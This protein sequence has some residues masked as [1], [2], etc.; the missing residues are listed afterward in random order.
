M[1]STRHNV[2][3]IVRRSEKI[4]KITVRF[5]VRRTIFGVQPFH[6]IPGNMSRKE[7]NDCR[8]LTGDTGCNDV[9]EIT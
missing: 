3:S 9:S 4:N 1:R 2:R 5:R 7:K 6:L 8:R